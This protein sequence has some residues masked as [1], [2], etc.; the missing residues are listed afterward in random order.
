ML[1]GRIALVTGSSSGIGA[2][3]ARGLAA[4]GAD[5]VVNFRRNRTGGECKQD[6]GA[7]DEL[8]HLTF[9]S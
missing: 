4:A 6:E 8:F 5:V 9:L 7:D 2:G 1:D 3:I